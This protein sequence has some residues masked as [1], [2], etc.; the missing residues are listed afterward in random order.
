MTD[1]E[2]FDKCPEMFEVVYIPTLIFSLSGSTVMTMSTSNIVASA[3][4]IAMQACRRVVQ[5]SQDGVDEQA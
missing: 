1:S 5:L 4:E 2:F 3:H